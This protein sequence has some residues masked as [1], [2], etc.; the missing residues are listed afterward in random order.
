MDAAFG[1]GTGLHTLAEAIEEVNGLRRT[2]ESNHAEIKLLGDK[3]ERLRT[4]L[5]T[6]RQEMREARAGSMNLTP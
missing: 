3:V 5:V 6:A 4:E 2:A 1:R